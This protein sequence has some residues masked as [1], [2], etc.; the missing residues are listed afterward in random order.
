MVSETIRD[1]KSDQLLTPRNAAFVIID[2]QP[3]QV[4]SIASMDR[5]VAAEQHYRLSQGGRRLRLADRSFHGQRADR[6]Q[7]A[8]RSAYSQSAG[9]LPDL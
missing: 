2:Y 7:Q 5:Q 1:P 9:R 4:N 3:V 8:A 6:A